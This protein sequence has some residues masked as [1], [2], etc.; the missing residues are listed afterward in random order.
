MFHSLKEY[1]DLGHGL[2]GA[3]ENP[4]M[5]AMIMHAA[6]LD[7][8]NKPQCRRAGVA[9][10]RAT[11]IR[12][13]NGHCRRHKVNVVGSESSSAYEGSDPFAVAE[14]DRQLPPHTR[15]PQLLI[16]PAQLS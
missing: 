15:G 5:I 16:W 3:H 1:F 7:P 4:K 2:L 14:R 11:A 8:S 13:W 12:R 10:Q 6:A 9:F